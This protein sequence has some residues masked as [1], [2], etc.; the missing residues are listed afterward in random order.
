MMVGW[1]FSI[2]FSNF[3]PNLWYFILLVPMFL[4]T[5]YLALP[6]NRMLDWFSSKI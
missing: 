4:V 5:Y 1:L 2:L 6:I 3:N